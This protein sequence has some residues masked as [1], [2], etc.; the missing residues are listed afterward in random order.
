MELRESF[1][2][3]TYD[4]YETLLHPD[5]SILINDHDNLRCHV[6][7]LSLRD[8]GILIRITGPDGEER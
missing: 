4:L 8:D 5:E 6:D 7:E 3:F 1:K 2:L